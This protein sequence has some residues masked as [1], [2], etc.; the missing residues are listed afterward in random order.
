MAQVSLKLSALALDYLSQTAQDPQNLSEDLTALFQLNS[1]LNNHYSSFNSWAASASK[2]VLRFDDGATRTYQGELSPSYRSPDY[3]YGTALV[4]TQV[5]SIPAGIRET[6]KG[7]LSYDYEAA[8]GHLW[9]DFNEGLVTDYRIDISGRL[10]DA[11]Y[12]SMSLGFTGHIQA[13]YDG[14]I[15]GSVSS[16]YSTA[17]KVLKSSVIEGDFQVSGNSQ[18]SLQVSGTL[19]RSFNSFHD[20]S[21]LEVRGNRSMGTA[22]SLSLLSLGQQA[23]WDGDDT[24]AVELANTATRPLRVHSGAGND[25][26]TLKG[27]GGLLQADAGDGNDTIRLLDSN[28]VIKG[29]DGNDTVQTAFSYSIANLEDI[30]ELS[31]YGGKKADATGNAL[32][33]VLRGNSAANILDGGAGADRLIGGPGNDTYIVDQLGDQI[34]ET[35]TGGI[36]SVHATLSWTLGKHLENLVLLGTDDLSGTGNSQ[37]NRITGNSGNNALDGAGG[38]DTLTGGAGDDTYIVDLIVKGSG[39]KATLA[40]Q[41]KILESAGNGSDTL[42]LR[43]QF[44]LENATMLRL[45]NYLENLDAS[46]TSNTRLNL[47]GNSADNLIIGNAANN[48]LIGGIGADRLFGGEGRD[49]FRFSS[50]RE[51]GLGERQDEILD[52]SHGEDLIDLKGLKGYSFIG[53]QTFSGLKQLRIEASGNDLLL[54][55]NA[56]GD[57]QADFSIKLVGISSLTA[58]DLLLA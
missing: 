58:E 33:N 24:F 29:G 54:L 25:N 55:G 37:A 14:A 28:P 31:L 38:L 23:L 1:S 8:H 44:E 22:D 12:G 11:Q 21:Y 13:S 7:G 35:A 34:D 56:N 4:H 47:T 30:E 26:L 17:Q 52:F 15:S 2:A 3:E 27:G 9:L 49:P 16:F 50:I 32:D 36:D 19:Q 41:D 42:Q 18:N 51:M 20:G 45:A 5:L 43:G 40:L 10:A 53:E 48:I 39:S 57:L 46:Q 6:I